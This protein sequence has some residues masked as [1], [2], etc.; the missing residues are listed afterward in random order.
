MQF[1]IKNSSLFDF[2][3]THGNKKVANICNTKFLGLTLDKTLSW[4]THI[5]TIIPK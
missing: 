1:V 3:I 4:K 2:N 5:D